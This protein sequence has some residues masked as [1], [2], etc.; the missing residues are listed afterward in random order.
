[1]VFNKKMF[2]DVGVLKFVKEGWIISDFEKVLKV[3]KNKGYIL[4]L[5]FVNG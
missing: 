2:K 4:G 3:L 1:M 5:F